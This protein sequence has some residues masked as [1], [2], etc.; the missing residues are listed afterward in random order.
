ML[1]SLTK[2]AVLAACASWMCGVY[3]CGSASVEDGNGRD[4]NLSSLTRTDVTVFSA[5][6]TTPALLEGAT[7][8]GIIVILHHHDATVLHQS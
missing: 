8:S 2:R 5:M 4:E 3:G 1:N 7:V 6:S